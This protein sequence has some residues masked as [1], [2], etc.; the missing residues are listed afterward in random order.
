MIKIL[1][2]DDE[3]ALSLPIVLSL[4]TEGY[5]VVQAQNGEQAW[6]MLQQDSAISL[7]ITD[8]NMPVMD[9]LKLCRTIR[10]VSLGRYVYT[11]L[12]TAN[13]ERNQL[14]EGLAAG[15]DDY[16][17]K[18]V[19]LQELTLRVRAGVRVIELER[20]LAEQNERLAEAY[21]R[22]K[23]DLQAAEKIQKNLLP[24]PEVLSFARTDYSVLYLPCEFVAGDTLN[25]VQLD[26][27]HLGFYTIDA[28][29]H[30]VPAAML[31]VMLHKMLSP[32]TSGTEDSLLKRSQP[33][34]PFYHLTPPA[35]VVQT[36]NRL[37]QD[38]TDAMQYYTMV[39]GIINTQDGSL[40]L[41]QA[42]HP[43]PIILR[44]DGTVEAI[45]ATGFPVGMLPDLEYEEQ[46]LFLGRDEC[47]VLYSDGITECRNPDNA[48]F[49]A[50]RFA[51]ALRASFLASAECSPSARAHAIVECL[52]ATL[53]QW[54]GERPFDDDISLL[55]LRRLGS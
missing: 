53:E 25:I 8:W 37:S 5:S 14:L 24:K 16:L 35:E 17:M 32:D 10:S 47:L 20:S 2:V 34:P 3:P 26:E 1:V 39:Y 36:L 23:T 15:A 22:I 48:L 12:L 54:R 18:P 40:R 4:R 9:G 38:E 42:G 21:T 41:C 46:S 7:V 6:Q 51:E 44:A 33:N 27:H 28:A 45:E 43:A 55:I 52:R 31:S 19:N 11:M 30:G 29:G 13:S 49:G 50:E